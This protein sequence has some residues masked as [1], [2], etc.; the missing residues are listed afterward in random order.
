M[1]DSKISAMPAAVTVAD[2]D[3]VPIVQGGVNK[4]AAASLLKGSGGGVSQVSG[5]APIDV[6]TGTT[7]P[8]VSIRAAT[9]GAAGSMS[10]ADKTKLDGVA[11][12]ATANVGTVTNVTGAAPIVV[13]TGT[14][15][16]AISIAAASTVAPGS[17]SAADKTK[18][19]GVTAGATKS[20]L[21]YT[22]SSRTISNTGGTAAVLPLVTSGA[23]GLAPQS[24]GGTTN[25]LRA[26]LTWAAPPAGGGGA[27]NLDGLTDVR[28]TSPQARDFLAYAG[29]GPGWENMSPDSIQ[30][31][32]TEAGFM[33]AAAYN[34][35]A[36]LSDLSTLP[37]LP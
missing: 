34:K 12:G 29:P 18:L 31:S 27:T 4:R 14:S 5:T 28:I 35:L 3:L 2:V 22:A 11:T 23:A 19:D 8:V 30:A 24:G 9:T 1:A 33:S 36:G 21:G 37:A 26:D 10:A 20:D 17:M 16:P 15:T 13:A 6:A 32:S 7:T 25:F